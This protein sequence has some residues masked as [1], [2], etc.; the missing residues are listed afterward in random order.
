M[1]GAFA[2]VFVVYP[3]IP[4]FHEISY[5]LGAAIA[6]FAGSLIDSSLGATVQAGY[7]CAVCGVVTEK[8]H[9][10][11]QPAKLIKGLKPIDNDAVNFLSNLIAVALL[12]WLIL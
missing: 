3:L 6:G 10:C 4:E 7:R 11:G 2:T 12:A 5:W 1:I 8:N 9:H